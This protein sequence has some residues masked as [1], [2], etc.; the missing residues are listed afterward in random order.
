[1]KNDGFEH[2]LR[3]VFRTDDHEIS[4]SECFDHISHFVEAELSGKNASAEMPQVRQHLDQCTACRE[5]YEALRDLQR[6]DNNG[7]L[8]SSDELKDRIP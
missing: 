4:C 3:N 2:W 6:L 5:E 7:A 1:M 8:P